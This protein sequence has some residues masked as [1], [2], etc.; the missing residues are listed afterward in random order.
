MNRRKALKLAGGGNHMRKRVIR[1]AL[2]GL[3]TATAGQPV[4]AQRAIG[5]RAGLTQTTS[6]RKA[7]WERSFAKDSLAPNQ[8]K[9]GMFIGAG[10]GAGLGLFF[11][12]DCA[13]AHDELYLAAYRTLL[14]FYEKQ[15]EFWHNPAQIWKISE[16]IGSGHQAV[17]QVSGG[18]F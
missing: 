4:P 15:Y 10:I 12:Y 8:W 6:T 13:K 2:A 14:T 3:I 9:K 17:Y 11:Y 1:L 7:P 18:G 16:C 5:P